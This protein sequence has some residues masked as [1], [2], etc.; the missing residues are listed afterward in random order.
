MVDQKR[1]RSNNPAL[2]KPCQTC[3]GL[4]E[5]PNKVLSTAGKVSP[6]LR[7]VILS[8]PQHVAESVRGM[9]LLPHVTPLPSPAWAG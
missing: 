2:T 8:R 7:A 5:A 6:D 3:K 9:H 4:G 1:G